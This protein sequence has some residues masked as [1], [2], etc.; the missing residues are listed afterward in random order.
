MNSIPP[1]VSD[2][3]A[4][5]QAD[6]LGGQ[7]ITDKKVTLKEAG[8]K[9]HKS[10]GIYEFMFKRPIDILLSLLIIIIIFWV[11]ILLA[12]LIKIKLGSPVIFKQPRPGKNEKIFNLYKFRTMTNEKDENGNLL[13]DE[14]RLTSFGKW[15]RKTS[16]DEIPEFFNILFGSMS[17]VGPRP[18]LIKYLPLYSEEQRRRHEVRPGLSGYAQVNGRNAISWSD[19]FKLDVEYVDN[20]TFI[21]DFKIV[22]DTFK[23]AIFKHDNIS[24][25][26]SVTMEDFTGD[27]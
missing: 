22:R 16:L 18:L 27:N 14:Q 9:P 25:E 1:S 7:E 21:G 6:G 17:L 4:T 12:I 23:K 11:Y 10:K 20:I 3:T 13:P 5:P 2:E 19:R 24:S 26:T 8:L 15:L